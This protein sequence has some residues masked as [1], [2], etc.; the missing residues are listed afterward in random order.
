MAAFYLAR[1]LHFGRGTEKNKQAAEYY[2]SKV[3]W[4]SLDWFLSCEMEWYLGSES[5]LNLLFHE[6]LQHYVKKYLQEH[7]DW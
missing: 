1:C 7:V 3:S 5:S 2:Y 6:G 4:E